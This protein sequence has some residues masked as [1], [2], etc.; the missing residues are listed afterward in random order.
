VVT[1][2]GAARSGGCGGTRAAHD[3]GAGRA[4]LG[5]VASAQTL[6]ALRDGP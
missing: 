3:A 1:S 4:H 5:F 6:Y 2:T